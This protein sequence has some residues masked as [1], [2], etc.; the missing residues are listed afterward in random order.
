LRNRL[1]LKYWKQTDTKVN[2]FELD[3]NHTFSLDNFGDLKVGSFADLV[4]NKATDPDRLRL[5]NDGI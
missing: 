1:P 5:A 4:K 2:S 3:M